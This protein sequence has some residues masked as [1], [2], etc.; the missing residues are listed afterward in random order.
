MLYQLGRLKFEPLNGPR[1]FTKKEPENFVS[2]DRLV[3]KPTLQRIGGA[4]ITASIDMH[5]HY[6]F[7]NVRQ[8]L[9]DIRLIKTTGEPV[10]FVN[11]YGFSEGMF[12][13]EDMN[14]SVTKTD[15]QGYLL[16]ADV[17][18]QLLEYVSPNP[19]KAADVAARK[20][21][22]ANASANPIL[23]TPTVKF[24][25]PES[26]VM[27]DIVSTNASGASA[28]AAVKKANSLQTQSTKYVAM[29]KRGLEK[30]QADSQKA[31]AGVDAIAGKISNAAALKSRLDDVAAS[32]QY[33]LSQIVDGT[34][35]PPTLSNMRQGSLVLDANLTNLLSTASELSNVI[36]LRK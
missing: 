4:L 24:A 30:A 28:S 36:T 27:R 13:I 9:S 7:I 33:I 6:T 11:G 2:Q 22:L 20:A 12:V 1:S 18:V 31:K 32:T 17:S 10:D 35:P 8:A 14:V 5:F 15:A 23:I 21:G 25:T 29:A 16:E 34:L 19:E 26:L 3:G